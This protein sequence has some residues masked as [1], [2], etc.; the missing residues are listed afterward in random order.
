VFF[1]V[2]NTAVTRGHYLALSKA[3]QSSLSD[4]CDCVRVWLALLWLKQRRAVLM[5][6]DR[7]T[8]NLEVS[9]TD[10]SVTVPSYTES[11]SARSLSVSLSKKLV[12]RLLHS[13]ERHRLTIKHTRPNSIRTEYKIT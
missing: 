9:K 12:Q 11:V 3:W 5:Y 6:L 4:D 10:P 13:L 1:C 7:L 8:K 2:D